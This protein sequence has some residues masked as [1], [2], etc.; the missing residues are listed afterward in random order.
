MEFR[1]EN[2]HEVNGYYLEDSSNVNGYIDC[3]YQQILPEGCRFDPTDYELIE[4]YLKKKLYNQVFPQNIILE[5]DIY[6]YHPTELYSHKSERE[7][8]VYF[9]T[10]RDRIS[11]NGNRP[12]RTA[13]GGF[14]KA[15]GSEKPVKNGQGIEVGSKRSLKF[16]EGSQQQPI[17]TIWIMNEFMVD[18]QGHNTSEPNSKLDDCVLCEIYIVQNKKPPEREIPQSDFPY[19]VRHK[20]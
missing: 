1:N 12:A 20:L 16:F 11:S 6:Q 14:W 19:S 8:A 5:A 2:I 4:F 13:K 18:N 10:P 7:T 15:S 17:K 3:Y 9:F